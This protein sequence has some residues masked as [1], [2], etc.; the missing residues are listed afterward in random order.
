VLRKF[1]LIF[2]LIVLLADYVSA[3]VASNN[4]V[5]ANVTVFAFVDVN[6]VPMDGERIIHNQ[7]VVVRNG[8]IAAMGTVKRVSVP[9]G[10]VKIDGRGR[11]LM[12]GLV[13]MHVHLEYFDRDAQL[14]LFLAGGVTSVRNM[15]GRPN[16]LVWRKRASD[17]SLLAPTIFTSG[18]IL[19]GKPPARDDNR[20]VET[21]AQAEA[22][23]EEQRRA[24]YDFIKVYH[25]LNRE[26]YQAIVAAAKKHGLTV[27]GHVP[28]SVG[29]KGAFAAGQKSIEHL[30]G[31]LDEIEAD[32]SRLKNQPSW[33]KRYFAV[34]V[35]DGKIRRIAVETQRARVWNVPT[36]VTKQLSVLSPDELQTRLKRTEMKYMD[37]RIVESWSGLNAR[38]TGRMSPEDFVSLAEGEKTRKRLVKALHDNGARLLVGTDTPNPFVIPGFSVL[39]EM[40][41]FV[42]A[43]LTPY[44]AIKAGTCD[45]AEFFEA[46]AE[47]GTVSIGKRADLIL[48]EGNPLQNIANLERRAGVMVRGRWMTTSDLQRQLNALAAS[49]AKK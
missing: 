49:Y 37:P 4:Q 9:K 1:C 30:E 44:Q 42:G 27:V 24:G 28:R 41:N 3:Q 14:L 26:T 31:Y 32:E 21:P 46:S 12:P 29:L 11:Y 6:V 33:L 20:V 13:D 38:I 43:G 5:A 18:P 17:G 35:D 25:T 40:Q 16:I 15:D 48:V 7:T 22:A 39:E 47:F 34:K 23:V 36:L 10:A 19:E 8:R 45:A 2:F